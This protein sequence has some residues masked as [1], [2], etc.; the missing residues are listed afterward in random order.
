MRTAAIY[1]IGA[2]VG[3]DE[4]FN[5]F[6]IDSLLEVVNDASP[7]VR[8]EL[9]LALVSLV[10]I[11]K[12]NLVDTAAEVSKDENTTFTRMW[13]VLIDLST[14]SSPLVASEASLIVDSI[15]KQALGLSKPI[16]S[17]NRNLV[18]NVVDSAS[19]RKSTSFANSL[20]SLAGLA[21]PQQTPSP[22][23]QESSQDSGRNS[24]FDTCCEYFSESQMR[25]CF[26]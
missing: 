18:P 24:F 4:E 9:V 10:E 16:P 17:P 11:Y 3:E 23:S 7:I 25:V 8:R 2:L 5:H 15:N 21:P 26:S 22:M 19:I 1:A 6:I 13:Q 12:S 20:R 14:D